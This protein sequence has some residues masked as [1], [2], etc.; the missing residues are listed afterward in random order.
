[1]LAVSGYWFTAQQ[2]ERQQELENQRA[3]SKRRLEDQ[4]TQDVALQ[5]YLH[6]M[7]Q[8]LLEKNLRNSPPD[9]E[10][11]TLARADAYGLEQAGL[12]P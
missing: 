2:E 1:M 10:V 9:S 5:E 6:Q 3:E 12:K 11:R 8:L 4:R 7:S